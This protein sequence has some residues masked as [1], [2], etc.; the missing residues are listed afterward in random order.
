MIGARRDVPRA[1]AQA[2]PLIGLLG[3][4]WGI[5]ESLRATSVQVA[6]LDIVWPG[7][8]RALTVTGMLSALWTAGV[9]AYT[10]LRR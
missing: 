7:V 2:A 6:T 8:L 10:R 1:V 4:V 3:T 9:L 5:A